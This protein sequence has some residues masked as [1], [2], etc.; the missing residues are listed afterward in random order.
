MIISPNKLVELL[1]DRVIGQE[2]AKR[3]LAIAFKN[4]WRDSKVSED[5]DQLPL[6]KNIIMV[7]KSG[8]GKS[9]LIRE[10]AD[11]LNLPYCKISLPRYINE[12]NMDEI[13]TELASVAH[14]KLVRFKRDLKTA[15]AQFDFRYDLNKGK[16]MLA[17]IT[18]VMKPITDVK[19][20]TFK[21]VY[22]QAQRDDYIATTGYIDSRVQ[23]ITSEYHK[24]IYML[25]HGVLP[26]ELDAPFLDPNVLAKAKLGFVNILEKYKSIFKIDDVYRELLRLQP[27]QYASHYGVVELTDFKEMY[28]FYDKTCSFIMDLVSHKSILT[29]Y[30]LVDTTHVL[31]ILNINRCSYDDEITSSVFNKFPIRVEFTNLTEEDYYR[32]LKSSKSSV[33]NRYLKLLHVDNIT[34]KITDEAIREIA[35]SAVT[36][37]A[38]D[39]F[40]D[41]GNVLTYLIHALFT[42][43]SQDKLRTIN[44]K[45]IKITL[46]DKYIKS[47][48]KTAIDSIDVL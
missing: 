21:D 13:I 8:V 19:Y 37:N 45:A 30:G 27:H 31:F 34:V 39:N 28:G 3:S 44:G 14:K 16:Q 11:L 23:S 22:N 10:S 25:H 26:V 5:S 42:I 4:R 43:I 32:I 46:D 47:I 33:L 41:G 20:T 15:E 24:S 9:T 18:D 40:D 48:A 38:K 29:K 35:K 2:A 7:G 12:K 6:P 36:L 1:A 17:E